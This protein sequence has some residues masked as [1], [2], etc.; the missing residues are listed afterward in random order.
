MKVDIMNT[1]K[2]Y[3]VIYADPPWSYRQQGSKEAVRGMARQHYST[4]STEDICK[5]P[6]RKLGTDSA[7]LFMWATFPNMWD[8]LQVMESWGFEYKT[9]AFVWVKE[10]KKSASLF[11]GMGAYTRDNAEVCLLGV[12]KGTKASQQVKKH[13][14]HQIVMSPIERHSKKPDCVREKIMELLGDNVSCIELFARE[15]APGWDCW[16]NE[17]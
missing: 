11:W 14:V 5:L 17:V 10:N 1:D 15:Y 13:N 12:S 4:M 7:I 2:K 16:G 9:A 8:A 3:E 6:V